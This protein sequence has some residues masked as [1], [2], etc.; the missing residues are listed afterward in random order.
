M[1]AVHAFK[2]DNSGELVEL[3][4]IIWTKL[5]QSTVISPSSIL[6]VLP[7]KSSSVELLYTELADIL[8]VVDPEDI[9][10]V[11]TLTKSHDTLGIFD[12]DMI[13]AVQL[14]K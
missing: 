6:T 9:L 4:D 13:L 14:I 2:I 3:V 10:A 12:V 8:G 11:H 5:D 7:V 1:L